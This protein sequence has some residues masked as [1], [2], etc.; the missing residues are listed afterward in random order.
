M[1]EKYPII[2]SVGY[3]Y[4]EYFLIIYLISSFCFIVI[5]YSLSK[6]L[7]LLYSSK[8]LSVN[9]TFCLLTEE[10]KLELSDYEGN[11]SED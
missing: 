3:T 11:N 6:I 5:L 1:F 10:N 4:R 8:M 7:E 2:G 9:Q